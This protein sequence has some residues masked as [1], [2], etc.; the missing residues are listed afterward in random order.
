M[1]EKI[2]SILDAVIQA[3]IVGFAASLPV[4][5]A[6]FH[7][8]LGV[9]G[10]AFLVKCFISR[11]WLGHR[12]GLDVYFGLF[13]AACLIS[14]VTSL[15]PL[16]SFIGLKKFFLMT[17]VYLVAYNTDSV[18]RIKEIAGF[19]IL[20]SVLSGIYGILAVAVGLQ[21]RL[22][23]ALGMAMT[24][25][26]VYM[27]ASLLSMG[28]FQA[29]WKNGL[30]QRW[31]NATAAVV[32]T[33]SLGLTKTISSWMGW[34]VG[35]ALSPPVKRKII[36][37]AVLITVVSA[38]AFLLLTSATMGLNYTKQQTWQA[39][40]TMWKI[41]WQIIREHPLTGVGLIDLGDIYQSKRTPEEIAQYGGRRRYSHLHNIFIHITAMTG[42]LGLVA[43][44]AM[45]WGIIS[46]QRSNILTGPEEIV[47]LSRAFLA[48]TLGFLL[49]GMAE[50]SYG[51]SEVISTLWLVTGLAVA[52]NRLLPP[53]NKQLTPESLP[54]GP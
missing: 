37:V 43:F 41:G 10:L 52:A 2:I 46:M 8:C 28:L 27:I 54:P 49:N 38:V 13:F 33:L 6:F 53:N 24:S 51:D 34:A 36:A 18:K 5:I 21:P 20:T 48:A 17:A 26:S 35:L 16:A 23:G 25:G 3:S 15:N 45:F 39:R 1:R 29:D 11:K 40:L 19:F 30:R 47:P 44:I 50:W 12:T 9:G 31:L 4:S 32:T 14:S 7:I 22:V 42:F